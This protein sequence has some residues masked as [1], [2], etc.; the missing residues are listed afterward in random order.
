MHLLFLNTY[1]MAAMDCHLQVPTNCPPKEKYKY[2]QQQNNV[3]MTVP[4]CPSGFFPFILQMHQF[5]IGKYM[6]HYNK[7]SLLAWHGLGSGKTITSITAALQPN[8]NVY[9]FCPAALIPNYE[10]ELKNYSPLV[11]KFQRYTHPAD[12][13]ITANKFIEKAN[14]PAIK[15]YLNKADT[16]PLLLSI[17]DEVGN[18]RVTKQYVMG[19]INT[20]SDYGTLIT[21]NLK[22]PGGGKKTRKGGNKKAT[23]DTIQFTFISSNGKLYDGLND[24]D[25]CDFVNAPFSGLPPANLANRI[26]II[27]E[28]QLT[29]SAA[30][31]KLKENQ[32]NDLFVNR[33]IAAKIKAGVIKPAVYP[34]VKPEDVLDYYID[35]TTFESF[36]CHVTLQTSGYANSAQDNIYNG[37]CRATANG[38]R[39]LLLSG[40][41]IVKH[42]A[43]IALAVNILS[44]N[45]RTMCY[46]TKVFDHN[47]G[48]VTPIPAYDYA[49]DDASRQAQLAAIQ[50]IKL[51]NHNHFVQLCSPYISYFKNVA[52]MMPTIVELPGKHVFD[53]NNKVCAN[54]VECKMTDLQLAWLKYL[55]FIESIHPKSSLVTAYLKTRFFDYTFALNKHSRASLPEEVP[56][57]NF[58]NGFPSQR[59]AVQSAFL[60][61]YVGD[62]QTILNDVTPSKLAA[63][64]TPTRKATP[65]GSRRRTRKKFKGGAGYPNYSINAKLQELR[66]RIEGVPGDAA[67]PDNKNKRHVIY[68]NSRIS[69]VMISRMLDELGYEEVKNDSAGGFTQGKNKFAF[70]TGETTDKAEKDTMFTFEGNEGLAEDKQL[71]IDAYNEE[72]NVKLKILIIGNAVAE[73]ITLKRTDFMHIY[74][75]PYNISKL[76]QLLARA[77]R[78]CVFPEDAA[79][80]RG[81]ITPYLYLSTIVPDDT[82]IRTA[83]ATIRTDYPQWLTYNSATNLKTTDDQTKELENA[84]RKNDSFVPHLFAIIEA[85]FDN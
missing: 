83:G 64:A 40:T 61:E 14:T 76:L 16:R 19:Q 39:L 48:T 60:K 85:S 11:L 35:Q 52:S 63:M 41:P 6:Q 67:F 66:K 74:S 68:S 10:N 47:F 37:F 84:I 80:I 81:L 1:N 27:D 58:E 72:T 49:F 13:I 53:N 26:G 69:N 33:E 28:S 71:L 46:N 25:F 79:G 54:I 55:E 9:V 2:I 24:K 42:P 78:N 75:F 22:M 70:L 62:F 77:N 82:A 56:R 29:V 51:K 7:D 8:N 73:G 17:L 21:I 57:A 44:G 4:V 45:S 38:A 43:E 65:G 36:E 18:G 12:A 20:A 59:F 5:M 3:S 32:L 15:P 30:L 34:P 31:K 50:Q 23:I